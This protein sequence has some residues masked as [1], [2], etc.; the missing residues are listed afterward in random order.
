MF[1]CLSFFVFC[2]S[3]R[4]PITLSPASHSPRVPASLPL[5]WAA[6]LCQNALGLPEVPAPEDAPV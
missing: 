2:P 5:Y 4:R 1:L 6:G 3:S